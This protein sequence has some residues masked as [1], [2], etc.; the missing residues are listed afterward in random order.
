MWRKAVIVHKNDEQ[1]SV[2]ARRAASLL[3]AQGLEARLECSRLG[4][5]P[6][7]SPRFKP[8]LVVSVGGDG[9]LLY[10]ARQWGRTGIPLLGINRG[11]LGFL[12]ETEPA[13]FMAL[14]KEV[15]AGRCRR[16]KRL[17]LEVT[18]KRRGRAVGRA[19]A[20]NEVVV[21]KGALSRIITLN[22]AVKNF[23]Q[24]SFRADGIIISTPTGSTAYN[25]SAGG[26]LVYPTL[27]A[28]VVT[29]ICPFTLTSRPLVLPADYPVT[30]VV[31]SENQ[32]QDIHLTADGQVSLPICVGDQ[33]MVRRHKTG[34]N[35]IVS[36]NRDFIDILRQ[37]I[38]WA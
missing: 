28:V 32:D 7:P 15:L 18:V 33:V 26:P 22:L 8:D 36:P 4:V 11:H 24:W 21:N 27:E 17:A 9:T 30:M 19:M 37:K 35:L 10:A 12:A 23:G 16:E 1:S 29:P 34:I 20:L 6:A 5:S 31:D 13:R 38:N 25:I 3:R 2:M 14:L